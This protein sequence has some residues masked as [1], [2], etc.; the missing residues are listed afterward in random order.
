MAKI[1]ALDIGGV[2][3][4]IK[5]ENTFEYLGLLG[6]EEKI[7]RLVDLGNKLGYGF[8]SERNWY[9]SVQEL[10]DKRFKNDEIRYAWNLMLG[11]EMAGISEFIAELINLKYQFIFFSDTSRI[12]ILQVYR[13][14]SFM[15][16]ISGGIFS[17]QVGA[18]KPEPKMYET[19]E[20]KYGKPCLYLDDNLENINA[21]KQREWQSYHFSSVEKLRE[22]FIKLHF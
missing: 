13:Q 22:D 10:L 6:F 16:L 18:R 20:N 5:M 7:T 17:Y 11:E 9:R 19:F 21:G 3:I 8:I 1:I 2:C 4:Q 14:L 15:P 12:H